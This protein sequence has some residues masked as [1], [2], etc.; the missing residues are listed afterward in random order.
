MGESDLCQ[1]LSSRNF[2]ILQFSPHTYTA[3][4]PYSLS[5]CR[6]FST[7]Q[8]VTQLAYVVT[9]VLGSEIDSSAC[10]RSPSLR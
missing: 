9:W 2:G 7:L 8:K 10:T 1:I 5:K 3:K 6:V 4:Y